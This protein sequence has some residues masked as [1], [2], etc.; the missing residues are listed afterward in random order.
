MGPAF[1]QLRA[2]V[3][4]VEANPHLYSPAN[5]ETA[6]RNAVPAI[7]YLFTSTAAWP[8]NHNPPPPPEIF[9]FG[10]LA[11]AIQDGATM[12]Q[13]QQ[14][15]KPL[16]ARILECMK[17][18]FPEN[19]HPL[20]PGPDHLDGTRMFCVIEKV[21]VEIKILQNH[22]VTDLCRFFA[23]LEQAQRLGLNPSTRPNERL[24][25]VARMIAT[26][27]KISLET[28]NLEFD[29]IVVSGDIARRL[30]RVPRN[31][32]GSIDLVSQSLPSLFFNKRVIQEYHPT[33]FMMSRFPQ[34]RSMLLLRQSIILHWV[35]NSTVSVEEIYDDL[36][37][38]YDRQVLRLTNL[39]H[40]I[41]INLVP[42]MD[43]SQV[44]SNVSQRIKDWVKHLG[45]GTRGGNWREF[46]ARSFVPY[47]D[48]LSSPTLQGQTLGYGGGG[49]NIF[50]GF[51][52]RVDAY[53]GNHSSLTSVQL[54][55]S[56]L[57]DSD[58][59][60]LRSL[61]HDLGYHE[62]IEADPEDDELRTFAT[63]HRLVI[64]A[65]ME[66]LDR[67]QLRP[68]LLFEGNQV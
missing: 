67:G 68:I 14:G 37:F 61:L 1:D 15:T 65:R 54:L 3:A 11:D 33:I 21:Y 46:R 47:L 24:M 6:L 56:I 10:H 53:K 34:L 22:S 59:C 51:A 13:N 12:E 23:M 44:F 26:L 60:Q 36:A 55:D 43:W 16:Y 25:E 29:V 57:E 42:N 5:I 7:D 8:L 50:A 31:A 4:I 30:S 9:S 64:L 2:F 48:S 35:G 58:I 32:Q 17:H 41:G 66:Y 20:E 62:F 49:C 19:V 28:A 40:C 38:L 52:D 45:T 63:S 27:W 18:D 39:L